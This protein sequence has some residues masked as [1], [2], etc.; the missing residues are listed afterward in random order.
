MS[1][2]LPTKPFDVVFDIYGS[3][4][5]A[6]F[7]PDNTASDVIALLT[8][9]PASPFLGNDEAEDVEAAHTA[10]RLDMANDWNLLL[11]LMFALPVCNSK[12]LPR[13]IG[14]EGWSAAI[15]SLSYWCFSMLMMHSEHLQF[16]GG[17]HLLNKRILAAILGYAHVNPIPISLSCLNR[18]IPMNA[19]TLH[20]V[21]HS[22]HCSNGFFPLT[23]IAVTDAAVS[24]MAG[25]DGTDTHVKVTILGVKRQ[26]VFGAREEF[27]AQCRMVNTSISL[28]PCT[29]VPTS[30]R[31]R[32]AFTAVHAR[33]QAQQK[34]HCCIQLILKQSNPMLKSQRFNDLLPPP[35][36][37]RCTQQ[38]RARAQCTLPSDPDVPISIVTHLNGAPHGGFHA[39]PSRVINPSP[40]SMIYRPIDRGRQLLVQ[41]AVV[42]RF[43]CPSFRRYPPLRS[44]QRSDGNPTDGANKE[45]FIEATVHHKIPWSPHCLICCL[46]CHYDAPSEPPS[47]AH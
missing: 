2:T 3:P 8:V 20:E 28:A 34:Q 43:S 13:L 17:Q 36:S 27:A 9:Q 4:P 45:I 22:E 10:A 21:L 25:N 30:M 46:I 44:E 31:Y 12:Y 42:A 18:Q 38:Y 5:P 19:G 39:G 33:L 29:T 35:K 32:V 14:F 26:V 23:M 6:T 24:I 7:T 15:V 47:R 41:F 40:T 1:T 37:L 11:F 16:D